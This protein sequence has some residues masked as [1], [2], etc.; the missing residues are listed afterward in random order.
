MVEAAV[1]VEVPLFMLLPMVPPDMDAP[2]D[3]LPLDDMDDLAFFFFM[4]IED[5]AMAVPWTSLPDMPFWA[6]PFMPA[7]PV[8]EPEI[9][10]VAAPMAESDL[11]PDGCG[12][13]M[14][15]A[16]AGMA[17]SKLAATAAPVMDI[18]M[19]IPCL[20]LF[21]LILLCCDREPPAQCFRPTKMF[22]KNS[23]LKLRALSYAG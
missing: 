20:G 1:P 3:M 21:R 8:C 13:L 9:L 15:W 11:P 19:G 2:D 18:F 14:P 16:K 5:D 17:K 6:G 23:D 4:L 7:A 12:A 22:Y 10:P